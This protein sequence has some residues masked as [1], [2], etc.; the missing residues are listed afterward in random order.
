MNNRKFVL[1]LAAILAAG[2]VRAEVIEED[3]R[4][5]ISET[6]SLFAVIERIEGNN[7][8]LHMLHTVQSRDASNILFVGDEI[9]ATVRSLKPGGS[10]R[11]ICVTAILDH[12]GQGVGRILPDSLKEQPE[13]MARVG[14]FDGGPIVPEE[15]IHLDSVMTIRLAGDL[16]FDPTQ[17]VEPRPKKA[18]SAEVNYEAKTW[19]SFKIAD[20]VDSQ[21]GPRRFDLDGGAR[22]MIKA[23]CR[24]GDVAGTQWGFTDGCGNWTEASLRVPKAG[25]SE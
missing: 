22:P 20:S 3:W 2:P 11:E 6:E 7:L 15:A 18:C 12:N 5:L 17:K 16:V 9:R 4:H 13:C 14:T 8:T 25:A 23:A 1:A 10:G 21:P 19:E 24:L